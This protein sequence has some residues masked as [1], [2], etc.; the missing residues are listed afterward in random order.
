[1]LIRINLPTNLIELILSYVSLVTTLILFNG[2]PMDLI[3]PSRGIRQGDTLS[4][5]LFILCVDYLS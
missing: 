4:P 2:S 1:M 5:Y 3:L